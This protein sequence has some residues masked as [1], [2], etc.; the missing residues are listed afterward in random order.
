MSSGHTD[1]LD[2]PAPFAEYQSA[3]FVILPIPYEATTT[4]GK[5]T[6]DGPEA[7]LAASHQV[8]FYDE[9]TGLEPYRAGLATLA[10]VLAECDGERA[11]GMIEESAGRV[12]DDSKRFIAIGGEH[13]ISLG[14][15][16]AANKRVGD[17]GV[18]HFDAHADLR[19]EYDA[20]S[21]SHATVM[22]RI[23]DEGG[24]IVQVGIRALSAG[25]AAIISSGKVKTFFAKDI[26]R[27]QSGA[28]DDRWHAEVLDALPG[29]V[30]VSFDIDALDPSVAPGTG[31]PEP[32]GL[33]WYGALGL[34]RAVARSRRI[35]AADVVEVSPV[36]GSPVTEFAAARLIYKMVAYMT[37]AD[38]TATAAV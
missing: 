2:P 16:R 20:V 6:G 30:Y 3:G 36:E 27:A 32:G 29:N 31:T 21:I 23:L 15:W 10:P 18:L 24:N 19:D 17:I 12:L 38:G 28:G 22:K 25:E 11:S 9:E 1:F 7:V 14:L 37:E 4:Y 8:E 13:T 35:V 26:C 33:T 34:L 5:G